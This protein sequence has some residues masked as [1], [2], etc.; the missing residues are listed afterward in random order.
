MSTI[1]LFNGASRSGKSTLIQALLPELSTPYFHYSSDK[2][3]E[4][5]ILPEVDREQHNLV[6]SWNVIRPKFFEGFHRSIQAFADAGNDV[7]VEHVIE[8][9]AWL[10]HLVELLHGHTVFSIGV[11]CPIDILN[12]RERARG[13]RFVGEGQSHLDDGIHTWSAYDLEVDTYHA[14]QKE[15]IGKIQELVTQTEKET[16]FERLHSRH[17]T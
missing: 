7:I 13:D 17:C 10:S 1:L 15:N 12:T 6:N 4:A 11:L 2:R 8:C 9:E 14:S 5:N 16:I 3:V